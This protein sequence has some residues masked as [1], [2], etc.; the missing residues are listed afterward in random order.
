VVHHLS[1]HP[2]YKCHHPAITDEIGISDVAF[3]YIGR[4]YV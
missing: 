3:A 2:H 1:R 4:D